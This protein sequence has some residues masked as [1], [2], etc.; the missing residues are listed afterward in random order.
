MVKLIDD[1]GLKKK[2]LTPEE[3][4]KADAKSI[5]FGE[6]A[7][8]PEG[9]KAKL[10]TYNRARRGK[11]TL[12]DAMKRV[13][14]AYRTNSPQTQKARKGE[15]TNPIEKKAYQGI[16][17]VVESYT[18][19]ENWDYP[20]HENLDLYESEAEAIKHLKKQWGENVDFTKGY[21][22]GRETYYPL[23]P[24]KDIK[25]HQKF[26]DKKGYD[27]G[28]ID[29]I[30][31]P[32]TKEAI[33]SF[34]KD[35]G[36][37]IDGK[38]GKNTIA[39]L[40][41][42]LNIFKV[43]DAAAGEPP[44]RKLIDD[45][46]LL[47]EPPRRKLIDDIGLLDEPPRRRLIDD[48]G[49]G[50][51]ETDKPTRLSDFAKPEEKTALFKKLGKGFGMGV[52]G[53]VSGVGGVAKW[54]GVDTV[55]DSI[56]K[57][58][59]EMKQFYDVPD[60][61][62]IYQ[63]ASGTGSM[64][65]FLIPGLGVSKGVQAVSFMPRLAAW[66]GASASAVMEASI[67]SGGS[68][69]KMVTKGKDH[70]E[71]SMAATKSFWLNL[72]VLIFTNKAG[73]FGENGN[74]ILKGIKSASNEAVQE[75]TQQ[76]IGNFSTKDPLMEGALESAAVGAIVGGGTGTLLDLAQTR[77][78]KKTKAKIAVKDA[79]G[80]I[81]TEKELPPIVKDAEGKIIPLEV[82]AKEGFEPPL[83]K[84]PEVKPE[85]VPEKP[86]KAVKAVSEP[87]EQ[88]AKKY[89]SAEEFVE[90]HSLFHATPAEIE[91]GKLKF[92][93]GK[94]LKK[95][96]YMGGHFLS[97]K[98]QAA[99]AFQFGGKMYRASGEI[100]NKVYDVNKNKKTFKNF[101]GKKFKN[102]DGE[103]ETFTQNHYD[104]MFPDGQDADWATVEAS[105][106]EHIAKKMGKIGF[107]IKEYAGGVDAVTYQLFEDEIPIYTKQQLTDIWNK[108]QEKPIEKAPVE[109][110]P[111]IEEAKKYKSAEEF[112]DKLS[113]KGESNLNLQKLSKDR[114]ADTIDI[115]ISPQY[116][117]KETVESWEK[118]I[119]QGERP[120]IILDK[121][122]ARATTID[123]SHRLKA[124][125][126]V[127]IEKVPVVY[128]QQLTDIWN[129]AQE[130]PDIIKKARE[131]ARAKRE[132]MKPVEKGEISEVESILP[133]KRTPETIKITEKMKPA[134]SPAELGERINQLNKFGQ[135]YAILRKSG[136]KMPKRAAGV[137][138][139]AGKKAKAVGIAKEGE[140][141]LKKNYIT[142]P[143]EY[144]T[145]LSHELGHA[146]EWN[147][148]GNI[149][150]DTYKLFGEDI[151]K[152]DV[153]TLKTELINVTKKLVGETEYNNKIPYYNMKTELFARFLEKMVSS[154]GDLQELAPTALKYM[155]QQSIK[156]PI[157]REYLEAAF[158]N[159]D[160]GVP[161]FVPL[162]DMRET[163]QKLLGKRVG[164]IAYN[165][166]MVHRAMQER[167][168]FVIGKFIEEKFKGIKDDPE[169]LFKAAESIKVTKEGVPEYGTRDYVAP[170]SAKEELK[171]IEAGWKPI[172]EENGEKK[173]MLIDGKMCPMYYRQRYT[174][175]QAKE[176]F[177]SLSPKGQKLI[178]D[179]TAERAEAKDYFNREV[180]KDVNKIKGNIE[181]WVHHYFEDKPRLSTKKMKFREKVAGVRKQRTGA[182]GYVQ[183]FQKAM[184]KVLIELEGEKS[185]N[186]FITRQLARV[187]KPLVEGESPDPGW[188]E[189]VGKL[190]KGVGL[191][192]EKR[193]VVIKDG[194]TFI[195]K[196]IRYQMPKDI[197][198]RYKLWNG[199]VDEASTGVRIVNDLNRYWRINILTHPG[200]AA[201]NFISGGIQYA[202]K[203]LTD[204]Y[205]ETLTGD[206]KYKKTQQNVSAMLKVLLPKGWMNAPDWVYGGDMSNY[207]GQ[208]TSQQGIIDESIQSYGNKALKLY[209][210]VERF[211]KK[212]ILTAENVNDLRKLGKMTKEGLELPTKEERQMIAEINKEVD[213]FAYDYDNVPMWLQAHQKSVTGQIIKP[214]MKYPY[215][216]AKHILNMAG[217]IFDRTVPLHRRLAKLLTLTTMAALY[218]MYSRKRK[219]KQETPEADVDIPARLSTRGR[220]Y[221]RTDDKGKEMFTRVAKYPFVN[222]TEAGM[223]FADGNW[224]QGKDIASDMLGSFGPVGEMGLLAMDY[225]NKFDQYTPVPIILGDNIST[226][227]PLYRI[228]SDVSRS[229]DPFKRRQ[230]YFYQTFTK[231]IPT[232]NEDLQ[233]KLHGKIRT[234]QIPVEGEIKHPPEYEGKR[235][236]IDRELENYSDDI[237]LSLFTGIYQTRIDPKE[238]EAFIIRKEKNIKEKERLDKKKLEREAKKKAK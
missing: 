103:M 166:E 97:D 160:K 140:V 52:T 51:Q 125:Q 191:P 232:T 55:G 101:I 131:K 133:I 195:P 83:I 229:M 28:D 174:P 175:A 26:L 238:V 137:F 65:T 154:P 221:M 167:G 230:E 202:S 81:L 10:D 5:L 86:V 49:L 13:S 98:E 212:T 38:V 135:A 201:T 27:V 209:G 149:N 102:Q 63:V 56:N 179:F 92:G 11:E 157:I 100:K 76:I 211:W 169:T 146:L 45:I 123:G 41:S 62:F 173:Y 172:F 46:G 130:K 2:I 213:L 31:G 237:L 106:V 231:I 7:N 115:S 207:Y 72:P 145:V 9:W 235:T 210:A 177:E 116:I 124:Y 214:F 226:F 219:E 216:Y 61:D 75:F 42:K 217:E 36:L 197:Y 93:A 222:L 114:F 127:G 168:K 223:Q 122:G 111:L 151:S 234:V 88:E 39:E 53:M 110:E 19:D 208:F 170:T 155:E 138:I 107:T 43:K 233:K 215:K 94:Q 120:I 17:D 176:I 71:A 227:M 91:G 192:E 44:R 18:P 108:A 24:E 112:V 90:S 153:Q 4:D 70:K 144:V 25:K 74:A 60:P 178:K 1:I 35:K 184:H 50:K 87:L 105:L 196:Q 20:H 77:D 199:L 113:D 198:E 57:Y 29:G 48:I 228:L 15:L 200:S 187:T 142:S 183:D 225:R 156:H 165:E 220:L 68:Y 189:V 99:Q 16:S 180:I 218:A 147:L 23:K 132:A 134:K 73:I 21:K 141:R 164:D 150:K 96:G 64:A 79:P 203:M 206:I 80:K 54:F 22:V 185:F 152:E 139:P 182:E 82:K 8:D 236:T 161:K 69:N 104:F 3:E 12:V 95:G 162:R 59:E 85:K 6:A 224:E 34:Q 181:G 109:P 194:K 128:K 158:S 148:L 40:L 193:T 188:V 121:E 67:E 163:Y 84:E 117:N 89:K 129:K 143:E 126:E 58:A 118:K 30:S 78:M 32:K 66:L 190:R 186:D 37:K 159:I 136:G 205:S 119:E 33:K 47:D 14:S 171:V 204:F